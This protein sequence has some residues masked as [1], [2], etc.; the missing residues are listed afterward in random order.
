VRQQLDLFNQ[1]ERE[2]HQQN[3]S[4]SL[5]LITDRQ[6]EQL[7]RRATSLAPILKESR[8]LW[9]DDHP[10]NNDIPRRILERTG[11]VMSLAASS[12]EAEDI[13]M[14]EP[15]DVVISDVGRDNLL[16]EPGL[17]FAGRGIHG[18]VPMIL[19]TMSSYNEEISGLPQNVFAVAHR[20]DFLLHYVFDA[21]ERG[22]APYPA[23][24]QRR[25]LLKRE[26]SATAPG[27]H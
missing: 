3:P 17:T 1:M 25:E 19:Y 20:P 24:Y 2:K 7:V 27:H 8:I 14:G 13:L 10:G 16:D 5:D 26:T 4:E 18:D 21:L 15:F 9:I 6:K 23:G 11:V 12:K 22:G